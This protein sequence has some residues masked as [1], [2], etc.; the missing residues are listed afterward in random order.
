MQ[1]FATGVF[2]IAKKLKCPSIHQ[3]VNKQISGQPYVEY[4][5]EIKKERITIIHA[6]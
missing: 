5:S 6:T 1:I 4:Y 3:L 2:I